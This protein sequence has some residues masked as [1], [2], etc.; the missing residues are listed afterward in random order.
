MYH[1]IVMKMNLLVNCLSILFIGLLLYQTFLAY[2]Y[3]VVEGMETDTYKEYD[4]NDAMI[5]AQ[6]NAGNIKVL[7]GQ[8]DNVLGLEKKVN[9]LQT[10]VDSL[11]QQVNGVVSAQQQYAEDNV[12]STPPTIT[13]L[14]EEDE[15]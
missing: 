1:H 15:E 9:D 5:L 10:T 6:Q 11:Q 4:Q 7:K 2:P 12:P 14:D 13:G 8:F 3:S